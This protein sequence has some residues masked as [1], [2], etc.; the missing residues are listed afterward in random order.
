MARSHNAVAAN[1]SVISAFFKNITE[2]VAYRTELFDKIRAF[3]GIIVQRRRQYFS[4][5]DDK[6][7]LESIK[8]SPGK[9]SPQEAHESV[10]T[11]A[12]KSHHMCDFFQE[13]REAF[14]SSKR[15]KQQEGAD[16]VDREAVI[17]NLQQ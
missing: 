15:S 2:N 16:K 13:K 3:W 12:Q 5:K 10:P 6:D 4:Q 1:A 17:C 7:R 9:G 14:D 8:Q 11:S